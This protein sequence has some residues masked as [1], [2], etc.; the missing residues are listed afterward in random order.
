MSIQICAGQVITNETER[1]L[2]RLGYWWCANCQCYVPA[3]EVTFDEKHD[4]CAG[5]CGKEVH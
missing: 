1:R 5:G 3:S 2:L 4:E